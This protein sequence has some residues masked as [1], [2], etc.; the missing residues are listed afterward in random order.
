MRDA[1][2]A[3]GIDAFAFSLADCMHDLNSGCVTLHGQD[4]GGLDGIVVKKLGANPD[5]T[6]RL[7]LHA[8]RALKGSGV[9]IFSRPSAI[10]RAMDR[11]RMHMELARCGLPVVPTY[12]V[13]SATALAA[14][15]ECLGPSVAKPVYTSKGRG[16]TRLEPGAS[17]Q[18]AD[19]TGPTLV[20]QYVEAPGRD[21]G[22]CVLGGAFVGAFYRV[23]QDGQWMTTTTAGGT[24]APCVLDGRGRELAERAAAVF[25]LDYTVVDLVETTDGYRIYEVSAFGGF[26]GLWEASRVDIAATYAR[27]VREALPR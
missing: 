19:G 10:E 9:R 26:R 25:G 20:Q 6:S 7:R 23:A 8:L 27:Y 12:A 22:A 17:I 2:C 15:L 14:A 3:E 5:P 16:M 24:Y 13:E 11:Y 4:L 21:I 18:L 1:L